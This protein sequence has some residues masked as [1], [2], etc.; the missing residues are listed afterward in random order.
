MQIRPY[1]DTDFD[2]VVA[3]WDAAGISVPYNDPALDIPRA[4][5]APN[6]ALFV[7]EIGPKLVGSIL[8]G[9]DGHRGWLYR[10]AVA[11]EHRRMGFGRQLVEH[12]ERWLASQG[13]P[14]INLMIRENNAAVRD[15]YVRLGYG[16]TP[17]L[18][19]QKGLDAA[20]AEPGDGKLEVVIT[21]LEMTVR[22]TRASIPHPAGRHALLRAEAP[23]V[24][25]YRFLYNTVGEP[26]FWYERRRMSDETLAAIITDP[27]VEIYVLYAEGTPAGYVELDR[28]APPDIEIALFGIM[29]QFIGRGFGA[30][31]LDWAL[32]QAW[33]YEPDRLVV[34]TC[35][36]DHP[37]AL[38]VYQRAGF[39]PYR[40]ERKIIDDPRRLGL[41]PA[42]LEPRLP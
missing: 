41:I 28:R 11:P 18:V 34:N 42:H 12:A 33:S 38:R 20:H 16:V 4:L 32:G 26:W 8:A 22:P 24:A 13:M 40:Q 21:H 17:R 5:A 14:K 25:F 9:H 30:F 3:L 27:K 36:L 6:A 2:A 37:K 7:G 35:T 10:L 23:T 19:M 31:L 29:P 1:V 15:F 39:V